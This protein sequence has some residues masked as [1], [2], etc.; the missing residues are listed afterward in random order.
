MQARKVLVVTN[1]VPY[2][3]KD[4]GNMA[5]FSMIDGY[6]RAGWQVHLLTMNTTRHYVKH[7]KINEIFG[8]LDGLTIVDID[9][10]I[11]KKQVLKNFFFSR[12]PEH[13]ERFYKEEFKAALKDVL[14]SFSPDAVQIESVFLSTYLPIVQ[15][16][17]GAISI[18]R[19]H[20]VE[21]Q[22]WQGLAGKT[23]NRLKSFYYDNLAT[24]VRNYERAAWK[25]YD[26]L[27]A[28]TEKD[29]HLVKRLEEVQ[30]LIVAPFSIDMSKVPSG[31]E[32]ADWVGY[33][34][35]AMDWQPNQDGVKW[36]LSKAWPAIRKAVPGFRFYFAGR[37][38]SKEFLD[39]KT[40]GVTCAGE[41]PDAA[42]FIA[43]KRIL[44]VPLWSGGGIRVKILE[45]MAAGKIIISTTKG[46]KGIE[47]RPQEHY[48]K[49]DSPH[50]FAKAVKWCMNNKADAMKI[51]ENAKKLIAEKYDQTRNMQIVTQ[52]VDFLIRSRSGK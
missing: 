32:T 11:S 1:R 24:R 19:M 20:N 33:H 22:I 38:M 15:K 16:Y 7:D 31:S 49:A 5:M 25:D 45:A 23:K 39:V 42:A 26:L 34:I 43:D 6:H 8:F 14:V 30:D 35:G 21:Y 17:S 40:D 12:Q 52:E 13:V 27:L 48:L 2:P 50:E 28:I 29:A 3:L 44:I 36:F 41:V 47:A 46:I 4:G 18:L 51:A 37:N 10:T 9:N